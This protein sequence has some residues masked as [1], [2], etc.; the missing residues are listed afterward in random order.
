MVAFT[1]DFHKAPL[2]TVIAH[3]YLVINVCCVVVG[4]SGLD[5]YNRVTSFIATLFRDFANDDIKREDLNVIMVVHG[6][7]LRLV[8][9]WCSPAA[10]S[11]FV[12]CSF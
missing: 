12:D 4:E 7:T 6:L 1:T 11:A 8:S 10:T 2:Q 5:V 9:G 3:Q